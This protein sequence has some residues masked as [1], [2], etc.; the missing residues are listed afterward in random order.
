MEINAMW[1]AVAVLVQFVLGALWYSPLM[2][3][4]W[5]MQIMEKTNATKAELEQMQ[6]EMA[7]FYGLQLVLTVVST[8]VLAMV[9]HYMRAGE[10]SFHAY[11]VA[12]WL[13]LGFFAPTQISAVIWANTKKKF[14]AKQ[15][16]VMLSYQLVALMLT[17][18]F[19]SL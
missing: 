10:P 4:K 9:I 17:A 5:W 7:P 1:F 8:F 3:G 6:K 13:W 14:W 15:I 11:G 2:F 18:F 19:L 16:F 12:G